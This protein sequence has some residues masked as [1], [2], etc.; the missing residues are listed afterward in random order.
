MILK[1]AI[2]LLACLLL[3]ACNAQQADHA[4]AS[5]SAAAH[6]NRHHSRET[7]SMNKDDH[8]NVPEHLQAWHQ[9]ALEDLAQRLQ[10]KPG[11]VVTQQAEAVT[12]SDGAIGCP[13]PDMYYTQALVPGYRL[14]FR[15]AGT[16]YYYHGQHGKPPFYCP[17]ERAGEPLSDAPD[18]LT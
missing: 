18:S 17:A 1:S 6:E 10:I 2:N 8:S 11:D 12:W 16:Q 14:V 9:Q 15:V 13:E 3:I 7:N 4:P 5:D